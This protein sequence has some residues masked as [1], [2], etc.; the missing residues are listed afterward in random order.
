MSDFQEMPVL[1]ANAFV[2]AS[3][4]IGD[5]AEKKGWNN[6][7]DDKAKAA[8]KALAD[9]MLALKPVVEMMEMIRRGEEIPASYQRLISALQLDVAEGASLDERQARKISQMALMVTEIYE[10][11]EGVLNNSFDDHTPVLRSESAEMADL[12]IRGLH[13]CHEHKVPI[14]EALIIKHEYNT[15]RPYR[16]GNKA[17]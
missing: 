11:A 5:W 9:L 8:N 1:I 6:P 2:V 3:K 10:G 15:K 16:H 4:V 12:F 7:P 14:N 13:Y 17:A